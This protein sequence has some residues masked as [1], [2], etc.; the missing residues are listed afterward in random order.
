M[1]DEVELL[2]A[3][4]HVEIVPARSLARALRPKRRIGQNYVIPLATRLF[5]YRIAVHDV[6]FDSVQIQVH[7]G[8]P[9]G[10]LDNLFTGEGRLLKALRIILG[11]V[12]A[13]VRLGHCPLERSNEE[14]R[15]PD[16][17]VVYLEVPGCSEIWLH[18]TDDS[19]Y[20]LT[21]CEVLSRPL[22]LGGVLLQQ[23]LIRSGLQVGI[24]GAP[25][26]LVDHG[27]EVLQVHGVAETRLG[28][29]K[30]PAQHPALFAQEPKDQAVM[31]VQFH[32]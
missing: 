2:V 24:D 18:A 14:T 28:S 27:D 7:Q 19:P 10:L 12:G 32:P 1:L 11:Q 17:W 16:R 8:Q 21:W 20:C 22:L 29:G 26:V 3:R 15:G 31:V 5:R 9:A 25:L 30:Y 4:G 13:V 6:T 23:T